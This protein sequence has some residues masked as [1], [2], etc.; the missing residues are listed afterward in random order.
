MYDKSSNF[1]KDRRIYP[2]SHEQNNHYPLLVAQNL[3]LP[4]EVG[5]VSSDFSIGTMDYNTGAF[6]FFNKSDYH[7]DK[8]HGMTYSNIKENDQLSNLLV[9]GSSD[10]TIKLWD[11]R[12]RNCVSSLQFS[13][14]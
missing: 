6:N 12:A 3:S 9:T 7:T 1:V 4:T 8:V 13:G 2:Y 11:R 5:V 14:K 10:K